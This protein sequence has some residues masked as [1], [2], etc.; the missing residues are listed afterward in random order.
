MVHPNRENSKEAESLGFLLI[1]Q[2]TAVSSAGFVFEH[3][4]TLELPSLHPTTSTRSTVHVSAN[5][6]RR[7]DTERTIPMIDV[8]SQIWQEWLMRTTWLR[9][10][11]CILGVLAMLGSVLSV[12]LVS[13]DAFAPKSDMSMPSMTMSDVGA[14]GCQKQAAACADCGDTKCPNL[15]SCLIVFVNSLPAP[16]AIAY[17]S[18]VGATESFAFSSAT[19]PAGMLIPPLIRPPI[20]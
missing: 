4:Q 12:P 17:R 8:R 7:C 11:C 15:T 20:V 5:T 1:G 6:A 16:A 19:A 18:V 13:A 3:S 14:E 9:Y 10:C 2:I